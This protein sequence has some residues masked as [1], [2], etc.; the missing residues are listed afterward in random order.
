MQIQPI[1][2]FAA[3]RPCE[4]GAT[5]LWALPLLLASAAPSWAQAFS[6]APGRA[7]PVAQS[8]ALQPART[9]DPAASRLEQGGPGS[10]GALIV[11][12][13]QHLVISTDPEIPT[14]FGPGLIDGPVDAEGR[15][16]QDP[17][18]IRAYFVGQRASSSA[19]APGELVSMSAPPA[20]VV[21]SGVFQLGSL[22]IEAGAV[23]DVVGKRPLRL[24]VS[25]SAEI[26]GTLR[27]DGEDASAHTGDLGFGGPG[28]RSAPGSGRG[29]DGGDRPDQTGTQLAPGFVG[30]TFVGF[31][32]TPGAQVDPDGQPGQ[33]RGGSVPVPG[34]D[35]GAAEGGVRWPS[36]F[37][38]P[39]VTDFGGFVPNN[40]CSSV[41]VGRP[42]AGGS[43]CFPGTSGSYQG[44]NPIMGVAPAPPPA[45]PGTALLKA[46]TATLDPD[47]G[48]QLVGG[49]GGGGGGT[50]IA[51]T[52]NNGILFNCSATPP[53]FPMVLI[54]YID[55]SGAGGG[56][57]G[58]A[59]QLR[60]SGR[61]L[62]SG[63]IDVSG[64]RGGDTFRPSFPALAGFFYG[65]PGG[66]GSGGA[67]LLQASRLVLTPGAPHIDLSGGPGGSNPWIGAGLRGGDGGPGIVQ[68][69]TGAGQALDP[70]DVQQA[71]VTSSGAP[72][73]GLVQADFLRV[74][75]GFVPPTSGS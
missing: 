7:A 55:A 36:V 58:G 46:S 4:L 35:F 63:L 59:V 67:L 18:R 32:H 17:A 3:F 71:I 29:G 50:G 8:A 24:L 56:S 69:E 28:A 62:L 41:Q 48:G 16:T 65:S 1:A 61:L 43:F 64:G 20:Q 44:P 49:A 68:I 30:S 23:L 13:G 9:S 5:A 70:N 75:S 27:V 25:G 31:L 66:G 12:S 53:G 26:A 15:P 52:K 11:R 73:V 57:G 45:L 40:I 38:G 42:G 39:Q 2:A 22:L 72:L 10:L 37:P 34:F 54:E 74:S 6:S 60:V 21:D 51:G 33:G 47:Q 14:V 19:G